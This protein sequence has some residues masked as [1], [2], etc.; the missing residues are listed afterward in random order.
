M[1]SRLVEG[2]RLERTVQWNEQ[3]SQE[4]RSLVKRRAKR[5]ATSWRSR[6]GGR[7]CD[8]PDNSGAP[9][10]LY[11]TRGTGERLGVIDVLHTAHTKRERHRERGAHTQAASTATWKKS[12]R[13]WKEEAGTSGFLNAILR[14]TN[15]IS[16]TESG[17]LSLLGQGK[18]D[19][20][21]TLR[22]V[23]DEGGSR[24]AEHGDEGHAGISQLS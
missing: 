3:A 8:G 11:T 6:S 18:A 7:R 23:T 10:A 1:L 15:G 12:S 2:R 13:T 19:A 22:I 20:L 4:Q 17:G 9:E 5:A 16:K 21:G 24:R 14:S